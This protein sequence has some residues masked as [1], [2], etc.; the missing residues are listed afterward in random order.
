MWHVSQAPAPPLATTETR[1]QKC[2]LKPPSFWKPLECIFTFKD[3]TLNLKFKAGDSG[4]DFCRDRAVTIEVVL[5]KPLIRASTLKVTR[6][7]PQGLLW[8]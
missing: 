1:H 8:R 5:E 4:E 3:N 6:R 7:R 2:D